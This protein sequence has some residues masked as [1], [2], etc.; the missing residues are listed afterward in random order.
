MSTLPNNAKRVCERYAYPSEIEDLLAE[1]CTAIQSHIPR[2]RSILLSG[3]I[4][5]G[6]L[7]YR[8]TSSSLKIFSDLDLLIFT[9]SPTES[10]N[11]RDRLCEME[12]RFRTPLFHIDLAINGMNVLRRIAPSY[13]MAELRQVDSVLLG[14]DL[15]AYFPFRAAPRLS[16]Q[17]L[18]LNL[19]K[20]LLYWPDGDP[21][22][23]ECFQ[24]TL[25]RLILDVPLLVFSELQHVIPGHQAR[26]QA[27]CQLTPAQH[28]LATPLVQAAV[29]RASAVRRAGVIEGI[30]L[31]PDFMETLDASL[32]HLDLGS[33][34]EPIASEV[35]AARF[36]KL[37]PARSWRRVA[38]EL[39]AAMRSDATWSERWVWWSRRKEAWAGVAVIEALVLLA[40]PLR[41]GMHSRVEF[42]LSRFCGTPIDFSAALALTHQFRVAYWK[43]LTTLHPSL[44]A[45]ADFVRRAGVF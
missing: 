4:A 45:N 14:E 15:R 1:L 13:Q 21:S 27:F 35:R 30:D 3:S 2:V 33:L 16:K 25:A 34:R 17:A 38:G 29:A 37:L 23:Q 7:V 39:R 22:R 44:R 8:K 6:D 24:W 43:G 19:W 36:E 32:C 31:W 9:E 18:I 12:E 10:K 40:D 20:A 41:H 28:P 11:F 5:T 26:A 42:C